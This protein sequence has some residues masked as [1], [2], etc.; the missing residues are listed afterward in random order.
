M[1]TFDELKDQLTLWKDAKKM[2]VREKA[3]PTVVLADNGRTCK[4]CRHAT[5]CNAGNKYFYK[6]EL[7]RGRWTGSVNTDIRL[8]DPACAMFQIKLKERKP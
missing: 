6:C 3:R 4:D 5:Y 1:P 7:N 8:R 2:G